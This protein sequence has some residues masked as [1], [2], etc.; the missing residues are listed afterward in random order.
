MVDLVKKLEVTGRR[1][2]VLAAPGDR[3]DEDIVEIGRIAA[4][5]FDH[6]IVRR[7]DDLRGRAPDEVPALMSDAIKK[8]GFGA[9]HLELIAD[10]E[11]A[12][13]AALRMGRRGDLVLIF[14]DKVSRCWKQIT[15][16]SGTET[17]SVKPQPAGDAVGG[18]VGALTMSSSSPAPAAPLPATPPAH[19]EGAADVFGQP[20][21]V[22][23]SE[24][25]VILA[26]GE[27]QE[28]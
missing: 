19:S 10:E 11:A 6:I 23:A 20:V 8:T 15:K 3:R 26:P 12:V 14:G 18:N 25:G 1:I 27:Q 16:F 4:S 13:D 9:D 24:R 21:P 28:D 17:R 2:C 22:I 5:A 7:D